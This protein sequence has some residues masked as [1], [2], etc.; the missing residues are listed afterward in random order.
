MRFGTQDRFS[1]KYPSQSTYCY[2]GNN[3]MSFMDVN[4][5]SIWVNIWNSKSCT[6]DAYYY[7][8]DSNGNKGFI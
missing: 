6:N 4:G 1:E 5:D 3:P 7:G 2:A 8:S